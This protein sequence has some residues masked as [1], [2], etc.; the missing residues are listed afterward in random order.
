MVRSA[1]GSVFLLFFLLCG[2]LFEKANAWIFQPFKQ[3]QKDYLALTRRVT[4][5]HILLP[6]KSE[7]VCLVLK[8]KIRSKTDVGSTDDRENGNKMFI[9][10]AFEQAAKN[11][12]RDNTTNFRGGL[13][14]ELSPQ[15]YCRSLELDRACFQARLGVVEGPIESEFGNHLILVTE[16]TNCP[17]LDG[18][19]TKVVRKAEN[20][21]EA[22]LVPSPQVGSVD[23]P[24]AVGQAA[25]WLFA[26]VAGG[27]LAELVSAML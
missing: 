20:S 2:P 6:P 14:G 7:E 12:S 3:V 10:D 8:Q 5:R 1:I 13:I 24:F 25:F 11:Y 15:G 18:K 9:V 27:L 22:I 4:A 17:N 21:N 26:F 23:I 19:N 16:R